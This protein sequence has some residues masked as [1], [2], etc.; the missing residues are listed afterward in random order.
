[1]IILYYIAMES[2]IS[3]KVESLEDP[4]KSKWEFGAFYS[5]RV[6]FE[7]IYMLVYFQML[8]K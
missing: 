1:M 8:T 2:G 6:S 7:G 3:V 5:V 4:M